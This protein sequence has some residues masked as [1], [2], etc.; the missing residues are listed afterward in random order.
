[1]YENLVMEDMKRD[2]DNA[3]D[4]VLE[5]MD[6][7]YDMDLVLET[8]KEEN[9]VL[10]STVQRYQGMIRDARVSKEGDKSV[11]MS[12]H[13]GKETSLIRIDARSDRSPSLQSPRSSMN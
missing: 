7:K 6:C 2:L 1:M 12:K 4:R 11:F 13:L 10:K 9:K 3:R 8:L 5:E